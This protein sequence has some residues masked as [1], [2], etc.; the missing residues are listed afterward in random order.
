MIVAYA[1]DAQFPDLS[2][3]DVEQAFFLQDGV[4]LGERLVRA[5]DWAFA[6]GARRAAALGSDAPALQA[7]W[8]R[9]G[10]EVLGSR[11]LVLGPTHDGGYH[12][13]GMTM[14]RP[15]LFE[16]MPWS[17]PFLLQRTLEQAR[18]LNLSVRQ[19]NAIADLD[20]PEDLRAFAGEPM[21]E[22]MTSRTAHWLRRLRPLSPEASASK[23]RAQR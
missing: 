12:L 5:F 20:T 21:L 6:R 11:D 15:S 19:L 18:R 13:I 14:L 23:S 3:L 10:L 8:I 7:G 22:H 9:E 4:T 16:G 17:S 1:A 2:W